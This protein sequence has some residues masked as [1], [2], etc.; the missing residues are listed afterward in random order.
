[1]IRKNIYLCKAESGFSYF[2]FYYN[3]VSD[4]IELFTSPIPVKTFRLREKDKAKFQVMKDNGGLL[5]SAHFH[6]WELLGSWL[7]NQGLN[8]VCV[9]QPLANKFWDAILDWIRRRI[10]LRTIKTNTVSF[11]KMWVNKGGVL[12]L[13][14]DQDFKKDTLSSTF[15][16][17]RVRMTPLPIMLK[18]AKPFPGMVFLLE[19][20]GQVRIIQISSNVSK[21]HNLADR[22]NKVLMGIIQKHPNYWYGWS[23]RRFKAITTY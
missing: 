3:M 19:P 10:G 12:G 14:W 4:L 23:H 18:S 15:F 13:L 5:F 8:L 6:N 7:Q 22:Y 11:M 17:M 1:M 16:D 2:R 9:S 21:T 20:D